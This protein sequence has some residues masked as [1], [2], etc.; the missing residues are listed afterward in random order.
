MRTGEPA[1]VGAE[2]PNIANA[3]GVAQ[4]Q[5]TGSSPGGARTI[6]AR[7]AVRHSLFRPRRQGPH[8]GRPS[9]IPLWSSLELLELD[10][11]AGFLELRL[12]LVC[13]VLGNAL[14]D[15]VGRA[16]DEVLGLLQA[17]ARDRADDLDHL[18]LLFAGARQD[19]VE[20]RLLLG[21]RGSVTARSR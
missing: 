2:P 10:R 20:R 4:G 8:W 1:N 5:A 15:R 7:S 3:Q 18:D 14:L 13:L 12:D 6:D 16:V 17:E 9:S 11:C 21:R 19:D